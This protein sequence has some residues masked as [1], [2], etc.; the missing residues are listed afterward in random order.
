[1]SV[2][3]KCFNKKVPFSPCLAVSVKLTRKL[4][5]KAQL[6]LRSLGLNVQLQGED[7]GVAHWTWAQCE[8]VPLFPLLLL[9]TYLAPQSSLVS[10]PGYHHVKMW[11]ELVNDSAVECKYCSVGSWSLI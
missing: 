6:L 3:S 4:L 9:L 11:G 5:F 1:M 2:H 8:F 10:M 7:S